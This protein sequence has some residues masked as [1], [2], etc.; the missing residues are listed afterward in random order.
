MTHSNRRKINVHNLQGE[1]ADTVDALEERLE[2]YAE[3]AGRAADAEH[4]W[5]HAN[6]TTLVEIA[7]RPGKLLPA[8]LR[9]AAALT[10]HADLH[11]AYKLA[12]AEQ[13]TA[14]AG[15]ATERARMEAVR[16]L[17]ASERALIS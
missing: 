14:K 2:G 15:L 7:S 9:N 10:E 12:A 6:A 5:K 3:V 13:D 16:T 8:D 1:L 17:I 11:R 4:A